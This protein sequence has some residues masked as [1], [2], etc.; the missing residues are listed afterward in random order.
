VGSSHGEGP[1]GSNILGRGV[2]F[3]RPV[4]VSTFRISLT[5]FVWVPLDMTRGDLTFGVGHGGRS[6]SRLSAVRA[7]QK[8]VTTRN[9]PGRGVCGTRPGA[10][11]GCSE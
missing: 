3:C 11:L 9:A 6:V 1:T 2:W 7:A 4:P 8:S 5:H 10:E